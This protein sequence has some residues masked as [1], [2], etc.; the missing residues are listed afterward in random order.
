MVFSHRYCEW[1][2]NW[3]GQKKNQ[4]GGNGEWSRP[5]TRKRDSI[6]QEQ[7]NDPHHQPDV[8]VKHV[9]EHFA[10][11]EEKEIHR[12]GEDERPLNA[13]KA[14]PK[15]VLGFLV[16]PSV[17]SGQQRTSTPQ[18]VQGGGSIIWEPPRRFTNV[19]LP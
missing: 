17:L 9:D 19:D 1:S 15:A 10:H 3:E 14:P 16:A 5:R 12:R 18:V 6:I 7:A 8:V 13:M 2:D 4:V 11:G